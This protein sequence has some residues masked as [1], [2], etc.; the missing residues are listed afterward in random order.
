MGDSYKQFFQEADKDGSGFLTL[1]ELTAVLRK[2]GYKGTDA[3]IKG[4][5]GSSDISG[6]NKISL[7]E[8]LTAMGQLPAK[9]HKTAAMR[10][11]FVSFDKDGSGSID[12]KEL[13]A[14]FAELGRTLSEEEVARM[15][16]LSDKD[17]SGTINYEEFIA[18]VFGQ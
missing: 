9:D 4:M 1:D 5:F 7:E 8:Y 6:D 12:R 14:V 13:Q 15:I 16:A 18:E 2:K 17:S 3:N 11:C 10:S